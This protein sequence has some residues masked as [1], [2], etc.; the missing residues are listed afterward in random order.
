MF[1]DLV[2]MENE[3]CDFGFILFLLKVTPRWFEDL[4]FHN[5]MVSYGS[6]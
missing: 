1:L 5:D 3:N 2:K 6:F 4:K